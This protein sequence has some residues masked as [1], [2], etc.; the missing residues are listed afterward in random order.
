MQV[1]VSLTWIQCDELSNC[2]VMNSDM[3]QE[4]QTFTALQACL[5]STKLPTNNDEAAY[6]TK[7]KPDSFSLLTNP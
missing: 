1:H 2:P 6:A 3:S 5:F 4:E 7:P